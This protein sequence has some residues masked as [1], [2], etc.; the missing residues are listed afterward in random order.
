[1]YNRASADPDGKPWSEKKKWVW[2]DAEAKKW[3]GYDVPDYI[4]AKPPTDKAKPG[5]AGMDALPGTAPFIM[6]PDGL[7]WLFVPGGLVDGPLPTHYEPVESPV[8]NSLYKQQTSPVY[9]HWKGDGNDLAK[10]GDPKFPYVLTTYR[11][12]EHYLAGGMSRWLPWS[13]SCSPSFSSRS[14]PSWPRRKASRISTGARSPARARRSAPRLWSRAECAP[15]RYG[16]VIH[17]VGMPWHWGYEGLSTGDVVN[18]LTSLIADPNVS[19]HEGK[20]FVCNVKRRE[21]PW[22][23][24][25]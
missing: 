2:W 14:V 6:R 16:K 19:M 15:S 4:A 11:L 24:G 21:A 17:Q 13:P 12:T 23:D 10:M 8:A 22:N 9:K 3:V 20:A 25:I 1:M 18:E 5:A 7:G